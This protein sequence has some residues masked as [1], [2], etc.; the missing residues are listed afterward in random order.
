MH[1]NQHYFFFSL[2]SVVAV[3]TTLVFLP[4]ISTLVLA[5]V[6]SVLFRPLHRFVSKIFS[7]GNEG[8][9]F[10][11][12]VTL[13]IVF[14]AVLIPLSF[15]VLQISLEAQDV[16]V[17]L[18][19]EGNR[20][21]MIDTLNGIANRISYK[22]FGESALIS[23]D[24]FDIATYI[25]SALEW[26]FTN[27][28]FVFSSFA[29]IMFNA[30]IL[31]IALFYML[32]DG[33]RVRAMLTKLSPLN[34]EYDNLIFTKLERAINSVIR[35]SLVVAGIQG[36]LTG[37]GFFLFGI[38]NPALWGSVAAIASLIPGVGTA[39][40]VVPGI[41]YLFATGATAF[42]VGFL[43]WG[44]VAVGLIDNFLGP[45]IVQQGVDVHEFLI[46]LSV[47]GGL[48]FFGPIGLIL[49]PL[50]LSLLLALLDIY[51]QVTAE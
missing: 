36:V 17:Y 38:P 2:L 9:S 49:G 28:D 39:L 6:F 12:C 29:T 22:I 43:V 27:I 50:S 31:L 16:Y 23:F 30:F 32:K 5:L 48:S 13:A 51:K 40:V 8:S 20:V 47:V 10:S 45:R 1:R 26:S 19:H 4:Y 7:R 15:L 41:I 33:S 18:T 14:A 35:G 34:D 3:L 44:V 21:Q 25:R 24:S 11:T 42:A 46:L 37:F